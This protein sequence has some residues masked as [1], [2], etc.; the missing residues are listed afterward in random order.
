[1][2]IKRKRRRELDLLKSRHLAAQAKLSKK[3]REL[4]ALEIEL[5]HERYL[6]TRER[7]AKDRTP[8]S[9]SREVTAEEVA[10]EEVKEITQHT[11]QTTRDEGHAKLVEEVGLLKTEADEVARNISL[12]EHELLRM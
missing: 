3:E 2:E 11:E 7:V 6:D 1:M 5:R 8:L 10:T 12:L 4:H 9:V